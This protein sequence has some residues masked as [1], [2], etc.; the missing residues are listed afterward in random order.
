MWS[1]HIITSKNI[2]LECWVVFASEKNCIGKPRENANFLWPN[3][4]ELIV[5]FVFESALHILKYGDIIIPFR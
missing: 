1:L 4:I 2:H 3:G 5:S